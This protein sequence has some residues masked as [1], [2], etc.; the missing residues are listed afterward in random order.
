MEI[1]EFAALLETM[2]FAIWMSRCP[3]QNPFSQQQGD[4]GAPFA[5]GLSVA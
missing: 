3:Q 5:Q 4:D 1:S 2:K